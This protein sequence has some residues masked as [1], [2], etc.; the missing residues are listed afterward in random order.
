MNR[1]PLLAV[2][3][4]SWAKGLDE[5]TLTLAGSPPVACQST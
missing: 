2:G 5:A 3:R 1:L 4:E